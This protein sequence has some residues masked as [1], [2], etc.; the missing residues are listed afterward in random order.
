LFFVQNGRLT[1]DVEITAQEAAVVLDA[2]NFMSQFPL[3]P[4]LAL[5][6]SNTVSFAFHPNPSIHYSRGE[7]PPRV[8]AVAELFG[9]V[10]TQ[11]VNEMQTLANLS[12]SRDVLKQVD[13]NQSSLGKLREYYAHYRE[14]LEFQL[15][16]R[17]PEMVDALTQSTIEQFQG[18]GEA[19]NPSISGPSGLTR[20]PSRRKSH[21]PSIFP[22]ASFMGNPTVN[23]GQ[24]VGVTQADIA[25]FTSKVEQLSLKVLN[26]NDR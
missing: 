23:T 18:A 16:K 3:K 22:G 17:L 15:T 9:L 6:P 19:G 11:G 2:L 21:R 4:T 25:N 12:S 20:G 13:I 8:Y 5:P 10:F 1:V 26:Y 24:S 7:N 14:A